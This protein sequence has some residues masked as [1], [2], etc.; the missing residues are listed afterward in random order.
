M[1]LAPITTISSQLITDNTI[2]SGDLNSSDAANFKSVLGISANTAVSSVATTWTKPQRGAATTDND[3]S[4]DL[5]G[6]NNFKCTPTAGG[7][8]TFT[9]HTDG[10]SGMILFVNGSNYA[11]TA[12]ATTKINS[13]DLATIS[14]TGTYLLSYFDNGTNTYVVVS[15]ELLS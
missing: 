5:N 14:V 1:A 12:A 9:N 8:L 4:F 13:A 7:T 3:L 10:Q 15:K 2:M 11:I 6:T